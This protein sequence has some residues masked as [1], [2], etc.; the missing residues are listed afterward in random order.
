MKRSNGL[1]VIGMLIIIGL[2]FFYTKAAADGTLLDGSQFSKQYLVQLSG[3]V[4]NERFSGAQTLL[5][6]MPP[7]PGSF[8]PYQL[9]L[10]GFPKK[11]SRNSFFW[12][13][14]YSEMTAIAN[15]ITCDIKRTYIKPVP[16]FFFFL[17]PELLRHTGAL[18]L[19]GDEGKKFAEKVALPTLVTARA[20]KL[21]IRIHADSVSG[22]IWMNGYDPVEKAF[23][24][25]S[26]QLYGKKSFNLVPRQEIRITGNVGG[27]Q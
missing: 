20:G 19:L 1:F 22:S 4:M 9:I 25:Y 2:G 11:N 15:E 24:R 27:S 14:M 21:K 18:E 16:I 8:N 17:S 5:T 3:T 13:G 6:I 12:N 23:V 26:A 7:I 10:Q